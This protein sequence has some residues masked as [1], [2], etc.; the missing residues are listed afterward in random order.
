MQ[1]AA[2]AAHY[3]VNLARTC[4]DLLDRKITGRNHLWTRIRY[5]ETNRPC[6]QATDFTNASS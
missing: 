6:D 2:C 3:A 1:S 4:E 5:L